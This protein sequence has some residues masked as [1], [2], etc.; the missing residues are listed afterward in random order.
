MPSV[1]DAPEGKIW[2][3]IRTRRKSQI[4]NIVSLTE[5][6]VSLQEKRKDFSR[7][8]LNTVESGYND[9]GYNDGTPY[10]DGFFKSIWFAYGLLPWISQP[11]IT[12]SAY[13]DRIFF[14]LRCRYNRI[15]LYFVNR[16]FKP[17]YAMFSVCLHNIPYRP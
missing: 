13:N 14:S 8:T 16:K 1:G 2:I 10:N 6:P 12:T 17:F 4:R 5:V 11:V 9:S 3:V 7:T 15:L